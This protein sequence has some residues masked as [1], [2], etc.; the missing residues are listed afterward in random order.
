MNLSKEY[1]N[2]IK[3][4]IENNTLAVFIGAGISKTSDTKINKLPLWSDVIEDL[5]AQLGDCEETDFLKIA[6]LYF[7]KP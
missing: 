7:L 2:D 6:E 1:I 4:A 3:R 5:R